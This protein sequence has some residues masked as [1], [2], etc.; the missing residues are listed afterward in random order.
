MAAPA[1]PPRRVAR[2]V[3]AGVSLLL[4]AGPVG[5][6]I[7]RFSGL[8]PPDLLEL[9]GHLGKSSVDETG[10]WDLTIGVGLTPTIY[11]FHLTS[12]RVLNS[13]H[14]PDN[15]LFSVEPAHPNFR[16]FGSPEEISPLAAATDGQQL[17]ITG[18]RR[19]GST[20]LL[21]TRLSVAPSKGTAPQAAATP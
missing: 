17:T 14:L 19:L 10:G 13:G 5:A 3:L 16:L 21:L 7:D 9:N 8:Q 6:Q 4:A 2:A 20:N 15:I 11:D 1:Q 18:Y 12:M